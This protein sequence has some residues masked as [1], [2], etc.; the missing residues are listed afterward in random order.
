MNE[1]YSFYDELIYK[2]EHLHTL[3]WF[4]NYFILLVLDNLVNFLSNMFILF[5]LFPEELN[6]L[7]DFLQV[8]APM[9]RTFA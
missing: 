5:I 1:E 2:L 4:T 3:L 6:S 7:I 9:Q 8:V